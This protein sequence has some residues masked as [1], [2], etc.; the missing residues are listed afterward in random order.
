MNIEVKNN[1]VIVD[2][3]SLYEILY[4]LSPNELDSGKI[5]WIYG[6]GTFS[7]KDKVFYWDNTPPEPAMIGMMFDS[8]TIED[9][10]QDDERRVQMLAD[11]IVDLFLD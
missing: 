2:T 4:K 6:D 11:S 10:Q 5:L 3:E 1:K 7:L 9:K 8:E